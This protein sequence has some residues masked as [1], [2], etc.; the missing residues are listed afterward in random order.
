M[1]SLQSR[2]IRS[3]AMWCLSWSGLAPVYSGAGQCSTCL[4]RAFFRHFLIVGNCC[5]PRHNWHEVGQQDNNIWGL[6]CS[7]NEENK[8]E[9]VLKRMKMLVIKQENLLTNHPPPISEAKGTDRLC[10][11]PF[12]GVMCH[13]PCIGTVLLGYSFRIFNSFIRGGRHFPLWT[14]TVFR[15]FACVIPLKGPKHD[16]IVC[17]FFYINPTSMGWWL[18]N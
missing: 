9:P 6:W 18:G 14:A 1:F 8:T 10:Y 16:Q 4:F 5:T 17:G 3:C 12:E 11:I 7:N 15:V 2:V 13:E